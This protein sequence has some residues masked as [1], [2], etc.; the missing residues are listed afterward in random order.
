MTRIVAAAFLLLSLATSAAAQQAVFLV[1]HG[2]R[3]DAGTAG[4][5][6]MKTDPE[7]SAAGRARAETLAAML[8]DAGIRA[9]FVTE[10]KRTQQ[11]AEP[12]AKALGI[13]PTIVTSRDTAALAAAI[14]AAK[15]NVLVVGHS[16]TVA[17]VIASLGLTTPVRIGDD[18]YDNLFVVAGDTLLHLHF[19]TASAA[20]AG[21][22]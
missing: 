10:Y 15:G 18:E 11:T 21:R 16:N 7:L 5:T 9:I 22:R 3:A 12:L 8:R 20:A 14:Q 13:T 4:A 1:R 17:D 6:M 2:E 19:G